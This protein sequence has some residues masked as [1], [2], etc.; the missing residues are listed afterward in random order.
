M[1]RECTEKKTLA[2]N[3]IFVTNRHSRQTRIGFGHIFCKM[4]EKVIEKSFG[5]NQY[6]Q[7][8]S[9]KTALL[10]NVLSF[11]KFTGNPRIRHHHSD[12]WEWAYFLLFCGQNM[13]SAKSMQVW[14]FC[15]TK[16]LI[17]G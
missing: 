3:R 10:V 16:W 15:R 5:K 12:C 4:L 13:T 2:Y 14:R 9:Y 11:S 7:H 17:F 8:S 1:T 6:N